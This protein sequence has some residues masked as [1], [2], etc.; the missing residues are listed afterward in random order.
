[1]KQRRLRERSR[2]FITEAASGAQ[3]VMRL[4]WPRGS[5]EAAARRRLPSARA[6]GATASVAAASGAR[7]SSRARCAGE[8]D[9]D[10]AEVA[11]G[12]AGTAGAEPGAE[13]GVAADAAPSPEEV[14]SADEAASGC[15]S[16]GAEL[17]GPPTTGC[18]AAWATAVVCSA[19]GLTC[20]VR[21]QG[22]RA[23]AAGGGPNS[24]WIAASATR[25]ATSSIAMSQRS[26]VEPLPRKSVVRAPGDGR[27]APFHPQSRAA[28]CAMRASPAS[29]SVSCR[30]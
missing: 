14:A 5:R 27:H 3:L 9:A 1:M 28:S 10:G 30:V 2:R 16:I 13:P 21:C 8:V 23:P 15:D 24:P 26:I 20:C 29:T 22:S 18:S 25:F 7:C 19:C 6:A 12:A 11:D 17:I 4:D